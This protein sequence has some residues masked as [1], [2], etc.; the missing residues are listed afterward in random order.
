[1]TFSP[2]IILT[3]HRFQRNKQHPTLPFLRHSPMP[4]PT[5][6]LLSHAD[7]E[8]PA[9]VLDA[10]LATLLVPLILP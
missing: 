6:P 4:L 9:R 2:F 8:Q 7:L 10:T 1:M 5:M 3:N